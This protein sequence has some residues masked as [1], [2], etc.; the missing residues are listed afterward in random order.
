M[1]QLIKFSAFAA[2]GIV[3]FVFVYRHHQR[4]LNLLREQTIG[5]VDWIVKQLDTLF[6]TLSRRKVLWMTLGGASLLCTLVFLSLLPNYFTAIVFSSAALLLALKTPKPLIAFLIKQRQEKFNHQMIDALTLMSN[7]LKSGLSVMQ[8]LE[9]VVEEMPNPIAQEFNLILAQYKIGVSVEEAFRNLSKR[10]SLEDVEMFVTSIIILRETG[11]NLAET[12]DTIAYTIRERIKVEN[13]IK[14]LTRQGILQGIIVTLMPFVL[15][16]VL[17]ML[18]PAHIQPMFTH[19]IGIALLA[20]MIGLQVV[21]GLIIRK[22]VT[23]EV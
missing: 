22:M 5:N 14:A 17:Y 8:A 13:K 7:A 3:T 6:I 4:V 19:P 1:D 20:F 23:I 15:A 18:D 12:F 10:L 2:V 21:G 9:L 11:G 16:F